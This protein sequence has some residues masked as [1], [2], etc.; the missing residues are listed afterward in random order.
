M[1]HLQ[2]SLRKDAFP[3]LS[4]SALASRAGV[5]LAF[6]GPRPQDLQ[7]PKKILNWPEF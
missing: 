3:P 7:N 1:A 5:Q 6:G 2:D 4:G